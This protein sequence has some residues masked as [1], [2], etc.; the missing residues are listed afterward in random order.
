[1]FNDTTKRFQQHNFLALQIQKILDVS[2]LPVYYK[3]RIKKIPAK[4]SVASEK[5]CG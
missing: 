2:Q 4:P 3:E 5:K 1:M